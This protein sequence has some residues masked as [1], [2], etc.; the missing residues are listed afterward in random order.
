MFD[1]ETETATAQR[2]RRRSIKLSDEH[3]AALAAIADVVVPSESVASHTKAGYSR[4]APM[5]RL[6][7][8]GELL[9]SPRAKRTTE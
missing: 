6:I 3:W 5:L 4:I 1:M 8:T 2:N 7:A 9:V